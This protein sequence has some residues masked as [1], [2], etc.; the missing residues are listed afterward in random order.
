MPIPVNLEPQ[1]SHDL[2][3]DASRAHLV[4]RKS[5]SAD[6][7]SVETR[8]AERPRASRARRTA[9]GDEHVTRFHSVRFGVSR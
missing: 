2:R 7:D 1:I 3:R 4:A 9:T 8:L 5:R 6:D